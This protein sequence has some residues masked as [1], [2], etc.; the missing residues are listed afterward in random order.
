VKEWELFL[1]AFEEIVSGPVY[2]A[3]NRQWV[4]EGVPEW[5]NFLEFLHRLKE[6]QELKWKEL[7]C[8]LG[9]RYSHT[10]LTYVSSM[11]SPLSKEVGACRWTVFQC[12]GVRARM[13][14][15]FESS[16]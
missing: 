11:T 2:V 4:K 1:K 12:A 16:I 13:A 14:L 9:R 15:W 3:E 7:M 5:N 6:H 10:I 8:S